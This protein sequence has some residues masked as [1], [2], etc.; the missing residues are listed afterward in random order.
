MSNIILPLP[1]TLGLC[2]R[3]S[4]LEEE[5][6]KIKFDHERKLRELD[7]M[8]RI[9]IIKRLITTYKYTYRYSMNINDDNY[10]MR[11]LHKELE[12]WYAVVNPTKSLPKVNKD[13]N[14]VY[15]RV[16]NITRSVTT[17]VTNDAIHVCYYIF[18]LSWTDLHCF[19]LSQ[20]L[21]DIIF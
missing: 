21:L 15:D 2:E 12:K 4:D 17:N 18:N 14:N 13:N 3:I 10:Y 8:L 7:D 11:I 1:P 9:E 19:E 6:Y 16:V 5:L 20:E